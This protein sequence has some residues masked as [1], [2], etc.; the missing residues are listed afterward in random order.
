MTSRTIAQPALLQIINA[1]VVAQTA[2]R[3][4]RL[5]FDEAVILLMAVT[6]LTVNAIYIGHFLVLIARAW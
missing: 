1:R 3:P 4:R 2:W 6:F 5:K